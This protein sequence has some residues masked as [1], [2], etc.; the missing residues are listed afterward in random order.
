LRKNEKDNLLKG[1]KIPQTVMVE[2]LTDLVRQTG[3]LYHVAGG[4][5]I[6]YNNVQTG[7]YIQKNTSDSKYHCGFQEFTQLPRIYLTYHKVNITQSRIG[8]FIKWVYHTPIDIYC[9]AFAPT[10]DLSNEA[11]LIEFM[12]TCKYKQKYTNINHLNIIKFKIDIDVVY[13][14]LDEYNAN[15]IKEENEHHDEINGYGIV[16]YMK[17]SGSQAPY[18]LNIKHILKVD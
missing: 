14:S 18:T 9:C 4:L 7:L 12:T 13:Y 15:Y 2:V 17:P 3:S 11:R 10:T 6:G 5:K 16:L 8:L 1:G